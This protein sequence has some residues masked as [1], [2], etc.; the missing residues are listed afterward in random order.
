MSCYP[1]SIYTKPWVEDGIRNRRVFCNHLNFVYYF[2]IFDKL[3][4]S[5]LNA[6]QNL[7]F[8][9]TALNRKQTKNTMKLSLINQLTLLSLDDE[10][11]SFIA[12]SISYSYSLAGAISLE[13]SLHN[14]IEVIHKNKVLVKDKINTGDSLLDEKRVPQ[15]FETPASN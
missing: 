1:W 7:T 10:N 8:T 5:S 14:R 4:M 9:H 6:Y 13:L 15:R 3:I 11:R 12:D 2:P